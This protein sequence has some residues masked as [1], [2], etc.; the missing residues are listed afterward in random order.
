VYDWL[1][2]FHVLAAMVWLGGITVLGAFAIRILREDDPD[3]VGRFLGSLR[4]IGPLVLAPAPVLLLGSGIW[5]VLDSDAWDFGQLWIDLALGLFVVAFA[6]G[7]AHQSRAALAAERAAEAG[8]TARAVHH[9][10]RWAWGMGAIVALLV[11]A[12]WAMVLKPGV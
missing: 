5:A 9:L 1:V 8:N 11:V 7:A 10:R 2:F 12:T 6:I 4:R 3:A